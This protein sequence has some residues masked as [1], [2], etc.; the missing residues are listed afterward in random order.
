LSHSSSVATANPFEWS[1]LRPLL[2][3]AP[4]YDEFRQEEGGKD[5]A[6][7]SATGHS[8]GGVAAA[9]AAVPSGQRVSF[10]AGEV[11][12][13]LRALVGT[14]VGPDEPLMD[15]G[16]DSLSA[17]EFKNA[18]E[19]RMGVELSATVVFDYPSV[20]SLASYITQ[21][22]EASLPSS[23]GVA[24][25]VAVT[26]HRAPAPAVQARASEALAAKLVS[27][28]AIT[29]AGGV[30][31]EMA[32]GIA[33]VPLERWDQSLWEALLSD[34]TYSG[35]SFGAFV[36]EAS[37]AFDEPA[38]GINHAEA[39]L[40]DPQQRLM[41]NTLEEALAAVRDRSSLLAFGIFGAPLTGTDSRI[42]V[43]LI[44]ISD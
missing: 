18:V 35:A 24:G 41:L 21:K 31:S 44:R 14:E 12:T 30:D 15:A 9:L 26:P 10:V 1:R 3:K 33:G 13:I 17:V 38:F 22:I 32:D 40:M 5:A 8:Q 20:S 42:L 19:G 43:S 29:A 25:V 23:G 7:H 36:A 34:S 6:A 2:G 27:S 37:L 39:V 4:I 16:L 28:S 11:L